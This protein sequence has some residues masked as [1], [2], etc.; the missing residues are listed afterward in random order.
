MVTAGTGAGG[1]GHWGAA[2]ATP[3]GGGG[4]TMHGVGLNS[5]APLRETPVPRPACGG[6]PPGMAL[7]EGHGGAA[8]PPALPGVTQWAGVAA[9]GGDGARG[10]AKLDRGSVLVPVAVP[11]VGGAVPGVAPGPSR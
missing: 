1:C 4:L 8:G 5:P 7:G 3:R 2:S 11:V 6:T 10:R 9:G